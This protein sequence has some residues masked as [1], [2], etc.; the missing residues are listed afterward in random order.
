MA[1]RAA[2]IGSGQTK[3]SGRRLDV[4]GAEMINEA[5]V[6]ALS[7]TGLKIKDIDGILIGNMDHFEGINYVDMWSVEATGGIMKPVIK[8]TTGGT[9]GSTLAIGAYHMIASGLFSKLLVIGWE[10]NSESDTTAAITTAFDPFWDRMVFAGAIGALAVEAGMYLNDYGLSQRD[11]ARVAVRDRKHACNNP[12]AHLQKEITVEEVMRSQMLADPIKALDMCPRTDGACAVIFADE[13][14]AFGLCS[15]PVWVLGTA[16]RH[17]YSYIG[18]VNYHGLQSMKHASR[19]LFAKTGITEPLK[20]IDVLEMYLPYSYAGLSW[21]ESMGLC[22][23]GEAPRLLWDGVTDMGGEL[24][25]NPS[26][27]VISCNPIG[28]TGLIRTAEA[29]LQVA[30]QAKGRQ[31]PDVNIAMSTGFGGCM[32]SDLLLYGKKKP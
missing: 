16:N 31:V 1:R 19:E 5:V 25:I 11:G 18:D 21:I 12:H 15:Q 9:T 6:D 10:K 7:N 30:G 13:Y 22:G 28:A 26:G 4:N 29:A 2:I 32:W 27:G 8:L 3:H 24:P 14:E 20:Q 17:D 23:P